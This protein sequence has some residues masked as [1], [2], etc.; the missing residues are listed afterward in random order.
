MKFKLKELVDT[1]KDDIVGH[2]FLHCIDRDF[3][4]A[5]KFISD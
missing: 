2:L 3:A 5:R 4:N 1:R